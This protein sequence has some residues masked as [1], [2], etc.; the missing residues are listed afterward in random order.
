M[1]SDKSI[2]K[3]NPYAAPV[4]PTKSQSY[5][6]KTPLRIRVSKSVLIGL[7]LG[8][9]LAFLLIATGSHGNSSFYS[10]LIL[11]PVSFLFAAALIVGDLGPWNVLTLFLLEVVV[12]ASYS[13][14]IESA[15]IFSAWRR[16]IIVFFLHFGAAF[17]FWALVSK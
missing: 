7:L 6:N 13:L 10:L 4:D 11:G 9:P 8:A 15:T 3:D 16:A 1:I 12:L 17:V 5:L 14:F 2:L